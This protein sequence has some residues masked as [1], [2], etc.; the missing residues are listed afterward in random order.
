MR[1]NDTSH[2]A[3]CPECEGT[4]KVAAHRRPTINDPY[5]ENP[6]ACGL[7]EHEPE[8]LVCGYTLPV[9]GF[10]CLAC[11]TVASLPQSAL[12]R[13]DVATFA[14]ALSNALIAAENER[15]AA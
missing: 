1:W 3:T 5:P 15:K 14:A 6:C 8:C 11:D 4:G 7:G 2:V 12:A 13:F 9:A 10:D